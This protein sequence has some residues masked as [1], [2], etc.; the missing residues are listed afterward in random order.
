MQK[1]KILQTR[2]SVIILSLLVFWK[3]L[4]SDDIYQ[5]LFAWKKLLQDINII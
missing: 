1:V 5:L 2:K 4:K 3:H